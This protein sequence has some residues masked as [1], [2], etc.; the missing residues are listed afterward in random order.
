M[1]SRAYVLTAR[2]YSYLDFQHVRLLRHPRSSRVYPVRPGIG[3]FVP[4]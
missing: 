2:R 3:L 1:V 4:N